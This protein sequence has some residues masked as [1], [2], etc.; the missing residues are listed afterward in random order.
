M[1]SLLRIASAVV[2]STSS[3]S[4]SAASRTGHIDQ[5][6]PPARVGRLSYASG[7]VSLRPGSVDDWGEAALNYPLTTGDELWTDDDS[8]AEVSVGSTAFRL[9]PYTGVE[10]LSL[11]DSTIQLRLSQGS[12]QLRVR[13]LH[14]GENIEVDTPN[15]AVTLLLAGNYRI[16]TDSTGTGTTITVRDGAAEVATGSSTFTVRRQQAARLMGFDQTR[17]RIGQPALL[18]RWDQWCAARDRRADTSPS[19]RYVSRDM[20]GYE[21]L[22][23][24]GDWRFVG[25]YGQ[26]WF[27][28]H[29]DADWA[30]YRSGHWRWIDPWGWTWIDDAPWGF[31]PFHYGRWIYSRG[32]WG[33]VPGRV[34]AVRPVYAPA[35]VVFLGGS[36]GGDVN[37]GGDEHV[38]WFPLGPGEVYVPAYRVSN[39]Y[40]RNVNVTSANVTNLNVTTID[41]TRIHYVNRDAPR[42]VT[43]VSRETFVRARPIDRGAVEEA[44]QDRGNSAHTAFDAWHRAGV[45]VAPP[46]APTRESVW[47]PQDET[48]SRR[49]PDDIATRRVVV[50]RQPPPA[51]V[52]FGDREQV[53]QQRPGHPADPRAIDT[54][55]ARAPQGEFD[56]RVRHLGEHPSGPPPAAQPSSTQPTQPAKPPMIIPP[57]RTY[58]EYGNNAGSGTQ[59]RSGDTT[60]HNPPP[61]HGDNGN[62]GGNGSQGHQKPDSSGS[63]RHEQP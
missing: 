55:R 58:P 20:P 18:D 7:S 8:R 51:P 48:R 13:A 11:D 21:D 30:P 52:P 19:A 14:P 31:A 59:G 23:D 38:A 50:K 43:I 39:T 10:L 17:F 41:V 47:P 53:L 37:R 1:W 49:P 9:A 54:I 46:V 25:G 33:W 57:R 29:V 2:I 44:Q 24:Y 32:F 40:V 12:V 45:A 34:V 36:L 61:P 62:G 26:V 27:P 56:R 42:G 16:D 63:R 15:G 22:D 28:Q 3:L 6:D 5:G 4:A 35:L 60:S